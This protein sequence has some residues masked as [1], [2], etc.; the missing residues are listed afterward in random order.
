MKKL[1]SIL[2]CIFYIIC[3]GQ[4][5]KDIIWLHGYKGNTNSWADVNQF[6]QENY[7]TN[8]I[9]PDYSEAATSLSAAAAKV[10]S[11]MEAG[12]ENIDDPENN[13]II[14]HSLGGL[15]SREMGQLYDDEL[16]PLFGGV[17]TFGTAHQGVAAADNLVSNP[18]MIQEFVFSACDALSA[19]PILSGVTILSQGLSLLTGFSFLND[20]I[21]FTCLAGGL[22]SPIVIP[23]F[24]DGLEAELT[25]TSVPSLPI[26]P[27]ENI[28]VFYGIEVDE[29]DLAVRFFGSFIDDPNDD[30]DVF[31]SGGPNGETGTDLTGISAF[32]EAQ[33]WYSTNMQFYQNTSIPWY[34]Y[35]LLP[36]IGAIGSLIATS[37][38]NNLAD[39]WEQGYNWFSTVNPTW[40]TMIGAQTTNLTEMGCICI[41]EDYFANVVSE[42]EFP[43]VD[44][45]ESLSSGLTECFS[46]Y[47][48]VEFVTHSD[49]FI[50]EPTATIIDDF[51]GEPQIMPGSGHLQMRNDINTEEAL[52]KIF[53]GD[54]GMF[55]KT[56]K[57]M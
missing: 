34:N 40:K 36:P 29:D 4:E 37:N 21:D 20:L 28:A 55:F 6:A 49:G 41:T 8:S 56:D 47:E 30:F 17:I 38:L 57:R 16:N 31:G 13:F 33:E 46:L 1:L 27:T 23:Y 45:C 3:L 53:S 25:T 26:L 5:D 9:I 10:T 51:T 22:F 42:E 32:N 48:T 7:Y 11:D 14:A 2:F 50:L 18:S 24:L 43:N 39:A 15:V 52:I 12:I 54:V 44:D 19:G 35:L